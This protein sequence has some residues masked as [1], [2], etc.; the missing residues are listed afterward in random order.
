MVFITA[1]ESKLGQESNQTEHPPAVG[2]LQ[3]LAARA[4][5]PLSK[6]TL[7]YPSAP[8]WYV[9]FSELNMLEAMLGLGPEPSL[10]HRV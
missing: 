1:S 6:N 7:P 9:Y 4:H 8:G 5:S 3:A 2:A 10:E